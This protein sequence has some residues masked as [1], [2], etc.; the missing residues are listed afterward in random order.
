MGCPVSLCIELPPKTNVQN[1]EASGCTTC[2]REFKSFT[3][4][5]IHGPKQA[6][7]EPSSHLSLCK[8]L[9]SPK[10]QQNT[11]AKTE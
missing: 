2:D 8:P 5:Q 4:S 11:E 10:D 6:Q 3:F 7:Q 9:C 1:K